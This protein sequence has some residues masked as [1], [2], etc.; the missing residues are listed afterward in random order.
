MTDARPA[1]EP[2]NDLERLLVAA[3]TGGPDERAAFERAVPEQPLWAALAPQP[4]DSADVIRLRSVNQPDGRPATAVFT[5]R[6]RVL[7]SCGPDVEAVSYEGRVLL[8]TIRAN[9][10]V[11]N[12]GQAYGVRWTSDAIAHLLG[13]PNPHRRVRM[14]SELAKP[15]DAPPSLVDNLAR[16]LGGEPTIRAAWLALARWPDGE[17]GFF[18]DIRADPS[19]RPIPVLINRALED[20]DLGDIRFDV[21]VGTPEEAPGSGVAVVPPR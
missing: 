18:L 19:E 21:V 3:A 17:E 14:P 13:T 8:Q 2:H 7:A 15:A 4:G 20:V 16:E 9:P 6:E 12:P 1:F 11:L 5:S 10:A